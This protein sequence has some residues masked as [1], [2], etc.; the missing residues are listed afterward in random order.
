MDKNPRFALELIPRGAK[1]PKP[2]A[3]SGPAGFLIEAPGESPRVIQLRAQLS[4][5]LERLAAAG[6][7]GLTGADPRLSTHV[8]KLCNEGV[9]II[10]ARAPK[11]NGRSGHIARYSLAADVTRLTGD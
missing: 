2:K 7:G 11:A 3:T 9:Q 4:T 5:V 8:R 6:H 1:A 10:T